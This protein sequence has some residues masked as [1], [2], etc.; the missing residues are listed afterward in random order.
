MLTLKYKLA[1]EV[2]SKAALDRWWT[3]TQPKQYV[4]VE[5][6]ESQSK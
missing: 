4:Y 3:C 5:E 1:E 6:V 2:K